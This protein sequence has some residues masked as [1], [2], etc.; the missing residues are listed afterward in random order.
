MRYRSV[1][2]R[3]RF[4]LRKQSP[5]PLR[6]INRSVS[7]ESSHGKVGVGLLRPRSASM[8]TVTYEC[9]IDGEISRTG[10]TMD[11]FGDLTLR[12]VGIFR[13]YIGYCS[14]FILRASIDTNASVVGLRQRKSE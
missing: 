1:G 6:V 9:E 14:S 13:H 2:A 7:D 3:Q 12:T 11:H 4:E 10:T 8:K 5:E